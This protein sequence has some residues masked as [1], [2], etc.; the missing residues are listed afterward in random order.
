MKQKKIIPKEISQIV[1]GKANE[2]NEFMLILN[3]FKLHLCKLQSCCRKIVVTVSDK[4]MFNKYI[5]INIM[6]NTNYYTILNQKLHD[7]II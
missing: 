2:T 4:K 5:S 6:Y 3:E 7:K 1:G